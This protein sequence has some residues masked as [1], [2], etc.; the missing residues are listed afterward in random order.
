ML[1]VV[2]GTA[3]VGADA[4]GVRVVLRA[5]YD[6]TA[7]PQWSDSTNWLGN[8][9]VCLWHGIRCNHNSSVIAL[10]LRSN[11]LSG[12]LPA[13]ING[14]VSLQSLNIA[15]NQFLSGTVPSQLSQLSQLTTLDLDTTSISGTVP[16]QLSQLS[17][18][19]TLDLDTTSI[20]GTVPSQLSQ[21]SQLTTLDLSLI[22]I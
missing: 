20:S 17:Q 18:L 7:G 21:L 6:A 13:E 9:S 14:L 10:D 2:L 1:L 15:M 16:S 12:T 19:T 11:S 4:A 3:L 8:T 22:H 5:L